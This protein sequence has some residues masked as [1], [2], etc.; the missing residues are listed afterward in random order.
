MDE[1]ELVDSFN[2]G[3]DDEIEVAAVEVPTEV[4]VEEQ[5]DEQEPTEYQKLEQLFNDRLEEK[6]RELESRFEERYQKVTGKLG[7]FN[8][9]L[10]DSQSTGKS[11]SIT[12][13]DLKYVTENFG[14]EFAEGLANDLAGLKGSSGG[15]D[16]LKEYIKA[17][18]YKQ[19]DH[20]IS[21]KHKG[22]EQLVQGGDFNEWFSGLSPDAQIDSDNP[23]DIID[24]LDSYK[25]LK[26][27]SADAD[28][29]AWKQNVGVAI[30]NELVIDTYKGWKDLSSLNGFSE[31][32]GRITDENTRYRIGR[33][34]SKQF[35][36][37]AKQAFLE[38]KGLNS[39]KPKDTKQVNKRLESAIL[40]KTTS[41]YAGQGTGLEDYFL[42]AFDD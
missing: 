31:W 16:T 34:T 41:D 23:I 14:E 36:D 15:E 9:K 1:N 13:D 39:S 6:S 12:K 5:G 10:L 24:L 17:I 40:P 37:S 18:E 7:E 30:P 4:A 8:R 26:A 29:L 22:W 33:D 21:M 20:I 11:L 42:S 28:F 19:N 2:A 38:Q 3:F 32:A 35:M 25:E 27:M